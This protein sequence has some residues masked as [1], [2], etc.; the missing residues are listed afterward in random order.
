VVEEDAHRNRCRWCKWPLFFI[1]Y[2]Q[3]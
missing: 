3:I 2:P 1:Y